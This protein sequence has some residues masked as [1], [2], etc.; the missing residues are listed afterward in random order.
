MVD[1]VCLF[2]KCSNCSCIVKDSRL[3]KELN[4]QT[5]KR[6]DKLHEYLGSWDNPNRSRLRK[7]EVLK[8]AARVSK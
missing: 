8:E 3:Y 2:S 5:I 4:T 7:I 1:F 6:L